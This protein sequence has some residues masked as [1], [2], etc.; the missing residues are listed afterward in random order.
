MRPLLSL[1]ILIG[2]APMVDLARAADERPSASF[3][4]HRRIAWTT[5]RVVGSPDPPL[6]Y[7]AERAFSKLDFVHPL[8][9]ASEP[10]RGRILVVEQAGKTLAFANQPDVSATEV[11]CEI[12]EHDT[13]SLAFH[14]DYLRNRYVY[15]F[16]NGPR[17]EK[18][19]RN[20]IL[21]YE[22]AAEPPYLCDPSSQRLIIE[23]ESNGHNGG[24]MAFG[25]DGYL[26]ISSGDGTSDSDGDHTGQ[27]ITDLASGII[28]IDIEHPEGD[29]SYSIPPDNP[30]L[31]IPGARPELWAYGFRNPW[32]MC[33]DQRSG[34]LWVGDIGQ[35]AWELI[36]LVQ[37]GANYG[38]S[39]YEGSRPFQSL[40]ERGPT[41]ISPPLVERP[42]SESRSIT[43]GFVYYG[44]RFPDLHGVYLYG[45]YST[46]KVW[47]LRYD[48]GRITWHQ[49]LAD[50]PL[51]ILGFG[52]D[53]AGEIYLVDYG[54]AIYQLEPSPPQT[55]PHSFPR[56][57][58]ETGL[59]TSVAEHQ[60]A[61]GLIP[62]SVNSP[63]WSD[64]AAKGRWIALPGESQV[65]F[66]DKG[67]WQFPEGAVLV[68]TFSLDCR[69]GEAVARRKVETRLLVLQQKEW[70][71]YSYEWNDEQTDAELVPAAGADRVYPVSD[72]A[73]DDAREQV[74]RFPS[75]A[76]CMVCHSRAAGFVLGVNTLQMNKVHDYGAASEN[77]LA[78]LE[79]LSVFEKEH[80]KEVDQ[81]P[82]LADPYDDAQ[83]LDA[84]ARSFLHANCAQCH[85]QAGGGNSAIDLHVSTPSAKTRL[86]GVQPLHDRL[87]I[88][89]PM[90]VAPGDPQRSILYQRVARLGAGRMPPLASV[91]VDQRAVK[92]LYDW[93][94]QLPPEAPAER[95]ASGER[96]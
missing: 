76:E 14:P 79:R 82:S 48:N 87:G 69:D 49:E 6:P 15:F 23:W 40:R 65:E 64:G 2:W 20:R 38:W 18:R 16:S 25:P 68:K 32:R 90:L 33:F 67:A 59:F 44:R 72:T 86:F 11:F 54:G 22:V 37:R 51:A 62:Y 43:G 1:A 10:G 42:H 17:G 75:R 34:R 91:V 4:L 30:F 24:E 80:P 78:V 56:R 63:L 39:V 70:V 81:Y 84:R 83:P 89:D 45:D 7:R 95:Q 52:T 53:A 47:G 61:P 35:D 74:W 41:P 92:L 19:K 71:G 12:P 8:Y 77:Q 73:G 9:L 85:V 66:T 26:Y 57:L 29:R 50:T 31:R 28:R 13:Y 21:R 46:G 55:A 94:K 27:D 3:D 60:L 58:S 36:H 88:A 96:E 5:S 93:I